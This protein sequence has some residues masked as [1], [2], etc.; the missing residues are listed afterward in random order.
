MSIHTL[1]AYASPAPSGKRSA[2]PVF[3]SSC[4]RNGSTLA[5]MFCRTQK[6]DAS[7]PKPVSQSAFMLCC[8]SQPR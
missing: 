3:G 7:V 8:E 5:A 4:P 6:R 1:A 2:S